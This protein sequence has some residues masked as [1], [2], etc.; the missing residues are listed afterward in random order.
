M[1]NKPVRFLSVFAGLFIIILGGSFGVQSGFRLINSFATKANALTLDNF[2]NFYTIANNR[3]EKFSK[4]GKL[5]FPYEE[6]RYGKIGMVDATNP[7][8]LLVYYPDYMTI[9]TLDRFLSPLITYDLFSMGYQNVSAVSSSADGRIW[10]YDNVDFKLKKIDEFGKIFRESQALNIILSQTPNPNFIQEQDSRI[11]MNDPNL[12]ILVF[13][14]FG[15]YAKTIPIKGLKKFQV[16]QDQIIYFENNQLNAYQPLTFE[17]KTLP[18]P[19]TTNLLHVVLEKDMI[20][21]LKKDK[22]EFFAY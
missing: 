2:G 17:L 14:L 13:D 11:Y 21:L 6:F 7:L 12:G 4:E 15:S 8:K 16:L 1:N 19:D 3:I 20:G 10:F 5:L 18:L 22:V 9:V